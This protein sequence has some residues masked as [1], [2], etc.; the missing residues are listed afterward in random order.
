ML[1]SHVVLAQ[2]EGLLDAV[3]VHRE[4]ATALAK[5][6]LQSCI[7]QKCPDQ[8]GLTL[9]T[10]FLELSDGE[11]A[12]AA[13]RLSKSKPPK[14]LE[15]V[16]GW[17]LGEAQAWAGQPSL[18]VKTL[19]KAKKGAPAWLA[20]RIDRKLAELYVDLKQ[21]KLATP[22]LDADPDVGSS[23]EL[24]YTRALARQGAKLKALAAA[25]WKALALRFPAH[26]HGVVARERLE[27]DG[28]W[29][30][31]PEDELTRA[32]ALLGAGDV[33]GCLA[34]LDSPT[35][36]AAANLKLKVALTRGQALLTRG[37]EQDAEA[38]KVLAP[39]LEGPQNVAAEALNLLARRAM[40][41]GDNALARLTFHTLDEKF[42]QAQQ[43]DEGAYLAAWLAMN[44]G[45][46]DTAIAE[47]AK[48]EE[49][50]P[51]SKK[52]DEARW[53]SAF[54]L[55]RGKKYAAA[56]EQLLGL[57]RDFPKSSLVP[58]ALYWAAH[59][60]QLQG[61]TPDAGP[62][63]DLVAEY[64]AVLT[65]FPG[66]FY[67]LLASERLEE[68]KVESPLPFSIEPKALTVKRPPGLELAAKLARVGLY[69]DMQAEVRRAL[70]GMPAADALTW[71]H[72]LQA[73]GDFGAAHT[74]A[75]RHLWGAVYSQ[76]QPEALALMYPRAFRVSVEA[77]CKEH[78]L[79][80]SMAW[81]I[82]RRESAFAPEVTS[83]ADARGL[84]QLIP[85]TAHN[86][87]GH[88]KLPAADDAELWGPD[89]NI[90]L[91]TWYL[92]ALMER[93]GHPTL[94]AAAYNGGPDA[95]AKW[96]KERGDE[97]L[98]QWV[99]EIPYKETRGYVKQVTT[100]LF[101]Y[102]QLYG[103]PRQRLSL[104]IPPPA[105]TGVNF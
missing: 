77:W 62:S 72:A 33:T 104:G 60:A 55:I 65:A 86:V 57:S 3:R 94:V 8:A 40:R 32:Q 83:F 23:P 105:P 26:P 49:R 29:S 28:A 59:A 13:D 10:G 51:D 35:L 14:G 68:L 73:M 63:V 52:R 19:V 20:Q 24:L 95:V 103:A 81:A 42:P 41:T 56:R 18:A 34:A 44:S 90:R 47:F 96:A 76:R 61:P 46:L 17:Y 58:Q 80:P 25:D 89:W 67:G 92:H 79:E 37:K 31:S 54:S 101:I 1:S 12:A 4:G 84:M 85:P 64:K 69:R 45:E 87:I 91:G 39:V 99:E 102:R 71:G 16:H 50:H 2:S 75:A 27:A 7:E 97:P 74:L 21:P 38:K 30:P 6:E 5:Q 98:D 93:L 11:P 22:L 36:Q 15:S 70:D 48:F 88:L 100:D 9:L 43:A 78:G 82:M 66:T 53:F